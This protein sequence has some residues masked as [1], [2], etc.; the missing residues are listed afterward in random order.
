MQAFL[1]TLYRLQWGREIE[2]SEIIMKLQ[3]VPGIN[4]GL[5]WGR[6]IEPS[7]ICHRCAESNTNHTLQW[8]REIEP[9][10]IRVVGTR[11]VALSAASMGPRD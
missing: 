10:E 5:Q 8:G 1:D 2:P 4:V 11:P 6:E 9:S 7:E 3:S